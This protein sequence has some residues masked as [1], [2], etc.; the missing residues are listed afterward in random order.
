MA[1]P[2]AKKA[3]LIAS[4][5]DAL[6]GATILGY[7]NV[8]LCNVSLVLVINQQIDG[9]VCDFGRGRKRYIPHN[10][11]FRSDFG[12]IVSLHTNRTLASLE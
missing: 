5:T 4:Y 3:E 10:D 8:K 7:G 2:R 6:K 11:V 9:Y 1:L 12:E